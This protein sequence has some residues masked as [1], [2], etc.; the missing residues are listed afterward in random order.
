MNA[1]SNAP[2]DRLADDEDG[3]RQRFFAAINLRG[4]GVLWLV[5]MAVAF[6]L[7]V[8][9]AP[10][11][12]IGLAFGGIGALAIAIVPNWPWRVLSSNSVNAEALQ[13]FELYQRRH[14]TELRSLPAYSKA[15]GDYLEDHA[16][17]LD[18]YVRRHEIS[19]R[20]R[21]RRR[22]KRGARRRKPRG[23]G[24]GHTVS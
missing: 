11:I 24:T 18:A 9:D 14:A 7:A 21:T 4:L 1:V 23:D 2:L 17:E 8:L 19:R 3:T 6:L 13:A 16:E 22:G 20:P 15:I 12:V 5:A 10:G